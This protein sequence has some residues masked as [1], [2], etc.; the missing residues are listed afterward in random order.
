M[1]QLVGRRARAACFEHAQSATSQ[2][3]VVGL[4]SR[5]GHRTL[6]R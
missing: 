6:A 5:H 4:Y 3:T 2:W 1:A